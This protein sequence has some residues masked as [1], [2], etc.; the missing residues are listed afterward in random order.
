MIRTQNSILEMLQDVG[1][2]PLP[3]PSLM[4]MD[5]IW[6]FS[7]FERIRYYNFKKYIDLHAYVLTYYPMYKK[8]NKHTWKV[9]N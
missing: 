3:C 1:M 2:G 5:N 9:I 6:F 8:V 7:I 4:P